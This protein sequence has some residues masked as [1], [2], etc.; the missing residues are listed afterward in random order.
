MTGIRLTAAA[1]CLA[2]CSACDTFPAREGIVIDAFTETDDVRTSL[3]E[4][5]ETGTFEV[6]WSRGDVITLRPGSNTS[7][8]SLMQFTLTT[9]EG[10]TYGQFEYNGDESLSGF[11][12]VEAYYGYDGYNWPAVQNYSGAGISFSPMRATGAVSNPMSLNFSNLGGLFRLTVKGHGFVT[13]ISVSANEKLSGTM[14]WT[15]ASSFKIDDSGSDTIILNTG[16]DGVALSSGGVPFYIAMPPRSAGYTGL[17]VTLGF[18]TGDT[19]VK[20]LKSDKTLVIT[21]SRITPAYMNIE[22]S[23]EDFGIEL[24]DF[25]INDHQW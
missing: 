19:V 5:A 20:T 10:Y 18:D 3:R 16:T 22:S 24:G 21:R 6:L 4:T 9:E 15:S 17:S 12:S 7:V 25:T 8:G 11:S 13:S 14:V 2:L 23:Q 1:L